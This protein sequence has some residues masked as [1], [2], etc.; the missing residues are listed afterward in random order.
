MA[1]QGEELEPEISEEDPEEEGSGEDETDE[2]EN[3]EIIK[4][5]L[6]RFKLALENVRNDF[7]ICEIVQAFIAG[8][9]WPQGVKAERE[10]LMRPCLTLDHLS[11][12]VR[13]VI[14]SGLQRKVDIRVM[15]MNDKGDDEVA[16]VLAGMQ[17]QITQT[18]TARVAYETGLRHACQVGWGY[19]RVK[20]VPTGIKD[21]ESGEDLL[22]IAVRRVPDPRMVLLDPYTE[23]PDAR[24]ARYGFVLTKLSKDDYKE[25]YS[26]DDDEYQGLT[27]W[28][29]IDGTNVL[30]WVGSE[31][32]C[33]VAEYF[34]QNKEDG[35]LHW[36]VLSPDKV[37]RKSV[38]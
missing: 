5:A 22:E 2:H 33:V 15:P 12:Y 28:H 7:T 21:E 16:D 35:L 32:S 31:G 25:Q 11:Q 26:P 10:G 17:R 18:S 29:M 36:A 24:D 13:F 14:N 30:P 19:W 3:E 8:D 34:Y 38:V 9:Q 20:V 1:L 27:S 37:L 4:T 23:Y 6:K